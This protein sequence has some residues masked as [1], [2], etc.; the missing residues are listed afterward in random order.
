MKKNSLEVIKTTHCYVA[1]SQKNTSGS[2][3]LRYGNDA[4]RCMIELNE[5][6][7]VYINVRYDSDILMSRLYYCNVAD[8]FSVWDIVDRKVLVEKF[9]NPF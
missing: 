1:V 3:Y 4:Y 6:R 9:S 7:S 5:D 2:I 8:M